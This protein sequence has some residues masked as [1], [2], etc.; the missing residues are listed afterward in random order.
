MCFIDEI[1]GKYRVHDGNQSGSALRHMH[2]VLAVIDDFKDA[3][4]YERYWGWA[5][6]RRKAMVIYGAARTMQ[7]SRDHHK[8]WRLIIQSLV[9]Y[10]FFIKAWAALAIN[11]KSFLR[12][13]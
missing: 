3:A 6:R 10:P 4:M 1:L 5:M 12:Y 9:L 13:L 2:A 7:L 11:C 8:A